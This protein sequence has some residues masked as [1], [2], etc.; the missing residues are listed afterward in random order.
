[1]SGN[2]TI[3]QEILKTIEGQIDAQN[4]YGL[5]KYGITLDDVKPD[6]YDWQGMANQELIDCVQYQQKEIRRL[7]LINLRL[8]KQIRKSEDAK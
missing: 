7:R 5:P 4:A 1:M 6:A 3:K 8:A 2:H